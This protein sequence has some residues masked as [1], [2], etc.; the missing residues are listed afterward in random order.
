MKNKI[1]KFGILDGLYWAYYA[2]F[3]GF[4][5]TYFLEYGMTTTEMSLIVVLFMIFAMIG[6]FFFGSVRDALRTNKKVF[7]PLLVIVTI[8]SIAEIIACQKNMRLL[9]FIHPLLAFFVSSLGTS[10]DVWMLKEFDNDADAFGKARAV[11]SVG[12]A[13]VMLICSKVYEKLGYSYMTWILIVTTILVIISASSCEET[14]FSSVTRTKLDISATKELFKI[15]DY[16]IMIFIL[17][18]SGLSTTSISSLKTVFLQAVGGNVA[19]LGI[20]S[21]AGVMAQSLFIFISGQISK[22]NAKTRLLMSTICIFFTLLFNLLATSPFLIICG[23]VMANIS[24]GIILPTMREITERSVPA[25]FTNVA[26]SIGDIMYG[27]MCGIIGLS[28]S[29]ILIDKY[30]TKSIVVLGLFIIIIPFALNLLYYKVGKK[31]KVTC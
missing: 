29:G 20:D 8:V 7:I 30:G 28:Y 3:I 15:P 23:T 1:I 5:T 21:F 31:E 26:H 17:F 13:I 2:V 24:Y 6:S 25:K 16:T 4:C 12:Y 14:K 11:G 9:F 18:F 19:T 22:I 27:N 10:I